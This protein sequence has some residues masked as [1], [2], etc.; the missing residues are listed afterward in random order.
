MLL[1]KKN[2]TNST[3]TTRVLF[4]YETEKILKE[5]MFQDAPGKL[6]FF[7]RYKKKIT[8][9]T[10]DTFKILIQRKTFLLVMFVN[11]F[12]FYHFIFS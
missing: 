7:S 6:F 5:V 9:L 12:E 10:A 8:T 4:K 2:S 3:T 1:L 11:L